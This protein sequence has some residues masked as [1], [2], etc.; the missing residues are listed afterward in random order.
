MS[1]HT[2]SVTQLSPSLGRGHQLINGNEPSLNVDRV[3][4]EALALLAQKETR[5]GGMRFLVK[6]GDP[7]A[8]ALLDWVLYD[9]PAVRES[10]TWTLA[11]TKDR[12]ATRKLLSAGE[13]VYAATRNA[14]V[15]EQPG[16]LIDAL[17][18]GSYPTRTMAALALG[19]LRAQFALGELVE[20]LYE[21]HILCRMAA[22]WALGKIGGADITNL[23]EDSIQDHDE[24]V[25][26]VA[27]TALTELSL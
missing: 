18:V 26:L 15:S 4:P 3:I 12:R 17:M 5:Q 10:A 25:R 21:Q 23:L 8:A 24:A 7:A 9:D 6:L 14:L 19:K 11:R 2:G 22:L 20:T 13:W 27:R 1:H 16:R